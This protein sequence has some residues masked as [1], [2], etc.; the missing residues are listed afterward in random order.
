MVSALWRK[1]AIGEVGA[2]ETALAVRRF[3]S[4]WFGAR[5]EMRRYRSVALRDVVLER[6]ASLTG[7]R[8]MR[9]L[10]A[11]QLASALAAREVEPDC[12]TIAVLDQRLRRAAATE[13]F[14]LLPVT[15]T[16]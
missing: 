4:D 3:E 6:A 1:A 10:D 13:G 14:D 11:I 12:R 5:A 15:V 8:G 2:E 9:S 16:R 7:T